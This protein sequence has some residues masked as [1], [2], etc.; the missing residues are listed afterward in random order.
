MLEVG[1]LPSEQ[2]GHITFGCLNNF[3]KISEP[4]LAAW[5]RLLQHVP[6]SQLLL[7]AHEGSH[8]ERL[9]QRLERE[10]ID[11]SRVCFVR[12]QPTRKYFDLYREIDIA[13]D[14]FPYG[15]GTTTCDALWMGVP[16]VSLVGKTAVGRAG[17]SILSNVGL[18]EL[19][20]RSED[21]YV[22]IASDLANNLSRLSELRSTLRQ[23]MQQSP[24][25]DAPR[26]ARN[27]EAAYRQ[28]WRRWRAQAPPL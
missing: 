21:E 6:H 9:Q 17:L 3:C 13:L 26:F 11:R 15:G 27:I 7:H 2:Q 22:R 25:M 4:A 14:T 5:G 12:M 10:G 19:A 20:A 24:L 23:R 8:R 1:P 16:V 18:P 28:M